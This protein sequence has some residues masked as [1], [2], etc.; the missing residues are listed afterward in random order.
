MSLWFCQSR[1]MA[2]SS[3][4]I[5]EGKTRFLI[6]PANSNDDAAYRTSTLE[7]TVSFWHEYVNKKVSKEVIREYFREASLEEFGEALE[8]NAFLKL[9]RKDDFAQLYL[10]ACLQLQSSTVESWDYELNERMAEEAAM[11][12]NKMGDKV[13]AAFEYR[14]AL[15][16]MRLC[17]Q[18][19]EL[20]EMVKVWEKK[21]QFCPDIPLRNRM[22]GY[23]AQSLYSQERFLE[24]YDIYAEL[25][26]E[27]SMNMCLSH[28][29]GYQGIKTLS[30]FTNSR[31]QLL[32]SAMQDYA[33]YYWNMGR[34]IYDSYAYPSEREAD[35][36]QDVQRVKSLCRA[37][38]DAPDKAMWLSLLAWLEM[39]DNNNREA[40]A[41]AEKVE[42]E[43]SDNIVR[44]NASRIFM[45]T[46]LRCASLIASDKELKT[47][48]QDFKTLLQKAGKE[49]NQSL[50]NPEDWYSYYYGQGV[51]NMYPN[52][53]FL[54]NTYAQE[55][56]NYL[57]AHNLNLARICATILAETCDRQFMSDVTEEEEEDRQRF[58]EAVWDTHWFD[59]LNREYGVEEVYALMPANKGKRNNDAFTQEVMSLC[60]LPEMALTDLMGTKLLREGRYEEA[61]PY[62]Q[63]LTP[64]YILSTNYQIYL[65]T[66]TYHTGVIFKRSQTKEP[67]WDE[68]TTD[69]HNYKAIFCQEMLNLQ[70]KQKALSGNEKAEAELDMAQRLFQASN[71]GD[72]WAL[73]DFGWSCY[74]Y[75]EPDM[76]CTRINQLL[77][78]AL[79]NCTND[80]TRLK[81]YYGIAATPVSKEPFYEWKYNWDTDEFNY[82]FHDYHP[83]QAAYEYLREHRNESDFT[84]Q[85]DVLKWYGI[86]A[87]R[88]N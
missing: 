58:M 45:L 55:L 14:V 49:I 80:R 9:L 32:Y 18:Q 47:I 36:K 27:R 30:G 74:N 42:K 4:A 11:S 60:H 73:T 67:D 3:P 38:L 77:K 17:S 43:S 88:N 10:T 81:I 34:Y 54:Q 1:M 62:L 57:S 51:A 26:D 86:W 6:V 70:A 65:A 23:Y 69:S 56:D 66:R 8:E 20:E 19:G 82:I 64:R 78:N 50:P 5:W 84:S 29:T 16:K 13:P 31:S 75:E 68:R 35:I 12:V 2:C 59:M 76:L 79:A 40:M 63:Q 85:C 37:H 7:E 25:G 21:G 28:Y 44:E 83:L 53:C 71:Q 61:L 72:L 22:K 33:N 48:A 46:R 15:L 39:C 24:A 41:L 52:Y 87:D